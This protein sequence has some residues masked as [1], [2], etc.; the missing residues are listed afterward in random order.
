MTHELSLKELGDSNNKGGGE[1]C[2]ERNIASIHVWQ[3]LALHQRREIK[4]V[5]THQT[6]EMAHDRTL[7][8]SR[9][10]GLIFNFP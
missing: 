5:E 6:L 1:S 10:A 4:V 2:I 3:T 8:A 7:N 9:D